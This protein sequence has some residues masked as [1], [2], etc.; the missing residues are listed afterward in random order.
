MD[1]RVDTAKFEWITVEERDGIGV[2]KLNRPE[3]LNAWNP[4][5]QVE[6]N[7]YLDSLNEGEYRVRA[8]VL[9]GEGRSFCAGGD[10]SRFSSGE[11]A[12]AAETRAEAFRHGHTERYAIRHMRNCDVPIV[13]AINGYAIGMGF[14]LALATDLRICAENTIFQVAQT[15]RGLMADFGL[16]YFL[17]Q[18][19]GTQ[20]ALELMFSGRRIDAQEALDLGL[21]L[22]VVPPDRL[23]DRAIEIA[24]GVA[25]GPPIG[26]AAS[27]HVVYAAEEEQLVKTQQLTNHF[28]QHLFRTEDATEGV[29]SFVE[30]REP[31]FRG[32]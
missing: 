8:I 29:R 2:V 27:K 21:V 4:G 23:L 11:S 9:S 7:A 3:K 5:M 1:N 17:P 16:S 10:V 24:T 6:M 12:A 20:K 18:A 30:R 13:G 19:V 22:E 32:R 25:S 26:L 31:Q 15:K 28:I 14:G